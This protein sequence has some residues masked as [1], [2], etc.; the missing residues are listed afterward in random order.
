M[1]AAL[2]KNTNEPINLI[3]IET[4]QLD[5]S[6]VLIKVEVCGL[7][8]T[9]LHIVDGHWKLPLLP[10][11]P[12]HEVVGTVVE[13]ASGVT[14]FTKG[15]RVGVAWLYR[16]CQVCDL[17]V[18]GDEMYCE[19]QLNAGYTVNGGFAEFIKAPAAFVTRI[20]AELPSSV[21]ATLLCAG[22]TPYRAIKETGAH[23][24]ERVAIFGVG[25]LG[26]LAVQIG[27]AMGLEIIAVDVSDEKLE[28]ARSFGADHLVNAA[29]ESP[30]RAI[31][32][33][34]GAHGVVNLVATG[35]TM[36]EGFYALRRGGTLV[37]VGLPREEFTL[38]IIPLVGRGIKIRGSV[39]GTRQDLREILAL[40]AAGKVKPI[41]K[42]MPFS[43][44][45]EAMAELREGRVMGR[46]VIRIAEN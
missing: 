20:P 23:V 18:E 14:G 12:G 42:E 43:Q 6:E 25:G 34:G 45:N 33:L 17:C 15:E 9:D 19:D 38:P 5:N 11:V 40:A 10:I 36:E 26:H 41:I 44:I 37:V 13:A 22:V 7:C 27:K 3:D 35:K 29:R 16:A 39:T 31:K 2:V 24:G 1:K 4:P 46:Y 28:L 21:A 32:K 8:H 30:A